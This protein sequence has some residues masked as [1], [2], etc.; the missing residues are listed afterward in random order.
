[1]LATLVMVIVFVLMIFTVFQFHLKDLIT[2]RDLALERMGSIAKLRDVY[3]PGASRSRRRR[4]P[5]VS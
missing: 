5:G 2:G 1:L 4:M 3:V